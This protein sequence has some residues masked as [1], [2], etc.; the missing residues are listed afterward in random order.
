MIRI[1]IPRRNK[2]SNGTQAKGKKILSIVGRKD[3]IWSAFFV[4]VLFTWMAVLTSSISS[5]IFRKPLLIDTDLD[6]SIFTVPFLSFNLIFLAST[7]YILVVFLLFFGRIKNNQIRAAQLHASKIQ[8]GKDHYGSSSSGLCSIIIPARNEEAV[9]R[10]CVLNCLKQTYKNIEVIVVC[11]NCTDK[12]FEQAQVSDDR[13]SAFDYRTKE[14]G[15]GLALNYAVSKAK[16]QFILVLDADGWLSDDFIE[17]TLPLFYERDYAAVQGR[18]IPSNRNYNFIT[19]MLA[20]EG[21][22]WSAPFMATRDAFEKRCPL[23]G[24][25]YIIRKDVLIDVGGFANHLVDDYELTFRLFRA[26]HRIAY[27]PMSINYDEK[28]PSLDFMLRQRARWV[29]GFM[30][31]MKSRVAE[32][33]DIVGNLYWLNPLSAFTS[34]GLLMI[35]AYSAL[36]NFIV[37]YYPF[38][39][40]Y[41]SFN[42][43]LVL[44]G[45]LLAAYTTGLWKQYG[46]QGLKHALWLPLYIPF[47]TYWMVIAIKALF[48]KSW[49]DTKTMHGFTKAPELQKPRQQ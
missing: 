30:N 2:T 1:G 38:E 49:A 35:S 47:S 4:G 21:D 3:T 24:T 34:F 41:L 17:M 26:K 39:Y 40:A 45:G 37:G 36:H 25:G 18:Y 12:T 6:L 10:K 46:K 19:R 14:A 9:I 15:K 33:R 48:V 20:L 27:A 13:V 8:K 16:G 11:H 29:K 43:W 23:G 44:N 7:F 5:Q 28:P 22:L 42:L 32:P 31:L